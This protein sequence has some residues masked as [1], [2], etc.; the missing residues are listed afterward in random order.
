MNR[1]D[2]R[3]RVLRRNLRMDAVAQIEH[4]TVTVTVAC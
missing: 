2:H 3:A 1:L 4:M